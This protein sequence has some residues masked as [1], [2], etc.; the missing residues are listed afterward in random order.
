MIDKLEK[1]PY[2]LKEVTFYGRVYTA[3]PFTLDPPHDTAARHA[4]ARTSRYVRVWDAR[5]RVIAD[6]TVSKGGDKDRAR[7]WM[8]DICAAKWGDV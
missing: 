5:G 3:P 8:L 6:G 4:A 1:G 2:G 7:Q